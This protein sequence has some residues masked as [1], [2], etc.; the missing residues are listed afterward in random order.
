[1]QISG[2]D[3][4]L[5]DFVTLKVKQK[6][7]GSKVVFDLKIHAALVGDDVK[8][9]KKKVSR[10]KKSQ[11]KAERP[12]VVKALKKKYTGVWRVVANAIKKGE[13]PDVVAISDLAEVS[14]EYGATAQPEWAALWREHENLVGQCLA[15]AKEG[16]LARAEEVLREIGKGKK[17]CHKVYK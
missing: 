15:A 2:I 14:R 6:M 5:S 3:L 8:P 10:S 11:K 13:C 1:V 12:Y 9:I 4:H 17:S 16:D 7:T